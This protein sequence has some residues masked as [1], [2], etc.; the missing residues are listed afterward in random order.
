[1]PTK[2]KPTKKKP[3]AKSKKKA[4]KPRLTLSAV[5]AGVHKLSLQMKRFEKLAPVSGPKGD[6]G[7]AGLPG[8]PGPAGASGPM[9][10]QGPKGDPGPQGPPGEKGAP[11]DMKRIEALERRVAALEAKLSVQSGPTAAV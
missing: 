6:P 5:A 11:A 3:A 7:P 9:G 8:V 10:A 2:V 4:S 1:M